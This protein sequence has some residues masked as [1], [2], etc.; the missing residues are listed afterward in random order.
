MK[1]G[2]V[3]AGFTGLSAAYE[4]SKGGHSVTVFEK[5]PMPGGLAV[6]YRQK[7][8][9]WS[10]EKHYHHWFT[11][12][13][14]VLNLAK[15]I[16]F[17]V[18]I[19][20]PKSSFYLDGNPYQFDSP[21]AILAFPKLP[22][23]DKLRMTAVFLVL[24]RLN[25]FW[26]S[27]EG[28]RVSTTLPKLIGHKAYDRL[29]KPQL[30]NKMGRHADKISLVWFWARVKKRTTSLAYP[31]GGF[32][33]FAETLV[34]AIEKQHGNV[35]FNTEIVKI[36]DH[37]HTTITIRQ[38]EKTETISFD[39]VIVTLPSFLFL[40]ITPQ[41]PDS[42]KSSLTKLEGLSAT[43]LLLRLKKPFFKDNTYW[44]SICEPD[45][46]VMAIIEH[47]N[48]MD[49]R[50]YNKEHLV[51]VGNYAFTDDRLDWD[52][53]RLLATYDKFLKQINPDYRDSLI[54]YELFKA[55][56]AQPI[57]PLHYS[58]LLPKIK[59]PLRHVFLANIEQVY[60]WDRGTNYAVEL[61]KKVA[62]LAGKP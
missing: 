50:H 10:L 16:G 32:L 24:F 3:G 4:L 20:T 23:P 37:D 13:S 39:R 56:F 48:F 40:K 36:E 22:L 41:L 60:P 18:A 55:P 52:K 6:G 2:I 44:M 31:E 15:E 59:T 35:V 27:L 33:A 7:E 45:A 47:T 61:G 38:H 8:W 12:D 14:S 42:Y 58:K 30:V 17:T 9:E 49:K 5:D 19:Q 62:G 34:R 28:L 21:K 11:N 54:D 53:K 1:I 57:V 26:K 29:W 43:N 51:Y 46:P 25:P